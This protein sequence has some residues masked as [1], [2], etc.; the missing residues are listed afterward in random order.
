MTNA[1]PRHKRREES[2]TTMTLLP[3]IFFSDPISHRALHAVPSQTLTHRTRHAN[4]DAHIQSSLGGF[5]LRLTIFSPI[6]RARGHLTWLSRKR[7]VGNPATN[8]AVL[9][10]S[11]HEK[12]SERPPPPLCVKQSSTR[13]PRTYASHGGDHRLAWIFCQFDLRR[14]LRAQ[15]IYHQTPRHEGKTPM[16]AHGSQVRALSTPIPTR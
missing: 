4:T 8:C 6:P 11:L 9:M 2:S 12:S 16:I 13:A 10:K 5:F 7:H 1:R 14:L 3:S 15:C